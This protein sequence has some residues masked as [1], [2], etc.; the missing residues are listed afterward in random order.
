[1]RIPC[2]RLTSYTNSKLSFLV[3]LHLAYLLTTQTITFFPLTQ[4]HTPMS[5]PASLIS[6]VTSRRRPRFRPPALLLLLAGHSHNPHT[7][8][9]C[10]LSKNSTGLRPVKP[11]EPVTLTVAR[12]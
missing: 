9:F 4:L 12:R 6:P 3:L 7:L 11:A 5:T 2:F 8:S 1:M 10:F